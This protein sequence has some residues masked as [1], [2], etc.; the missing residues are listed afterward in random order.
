MKKLVFLTGV[1]FLLVGG[2]A[3]QNQ[4]TDDLECGSD[5]V[6]PGLGPLWEVDK[7]VD[8][9][10]AS[11]E[12]RVNERATEVCVAVKNNQT[13]AARRAVNAVQMA[14]DKHP[15]ENPEGLDTA[16]DNLDRVYNQVPEKAQEVGVNNAIN[17]VRAVKDGRTDVPRLTNPAFS[18]EGN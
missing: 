5:L 17:H 8:S 14:A 1:A 15:D 11:S 13:A 3:A 9:V 7:F 16:L 18:P 2:V 10:V 4:S 12:A 6:G